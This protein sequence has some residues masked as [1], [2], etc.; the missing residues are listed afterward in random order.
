M[1]F[2][3]GSLKLDDSKKGGLFSKPNS[4]NSAK[5]KEKGAMMK[6]LANA[7]K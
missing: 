2:N 4:A 7:C 3:K 5:P 6:S 1:E